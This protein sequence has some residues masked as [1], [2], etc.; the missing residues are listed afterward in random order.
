MSG[1]SYGTENLIE[2]KGSTQPLKIDT[3]MGSALAQMR[4][5]LL[6]AAGLRTEA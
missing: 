4:A 5:A 1:T 6:G 2:K 3:R